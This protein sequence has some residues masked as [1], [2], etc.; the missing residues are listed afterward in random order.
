MKRAEIAASYYF[1]SFADERFG[2]TVGISLR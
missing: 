1:D 2:L